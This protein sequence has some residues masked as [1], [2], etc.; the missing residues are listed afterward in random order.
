MMD[1]NKHIVDQRINKIVKD[2]PE[3]FESDNDYNKKLSK[4]FLILGMASYLDFELKDVLPLITEGGNDCGIDA[5]YI[6][7]VSETEFTVILFQS[8][9]KF[10]LEN[11]SNFPA[12]SIIRVIDAV[13]GI[14][15]PSRDLLTNNVIKPKITEIQSLLLDGNIPNIIC[16][17]MNN[18]DSWNEEGN[19]HIK[20]ANFGDQVVFEHYNHKKIVEHI[21]K[22][23]PVSDTISI[24]GKG[25]VEEFNFKRVLI[26]KISVKEIVR[27]ANNHGDSLF[28]KNI[29][30]Y[31]GINKN[32]VNEAIR[33]T[34]VD[35]EKKNNFFFYNNGITMVCTKFS[36][37]A[38]ASENWII[39]VEDMQIINGGQTCKTIQETI[40]NNP[41]IDYSQVYVL[42]RLYEVYPY[43]DDDVI[44]DITIATNSQ[45]PV[46]LRDLKANEELQRKLEMSVKGLGFTYKRKREGVSSTDAIPSSVAAEAVC[47]I[48]RRKP[49]V[50]KYKRNELFGKFYNDIFNNLNAAQLVL[51]VLIFRYCDNQRKKMP[52][53]GL[54]SH[55]PYSNYFMAMKLGDLLLN[56]MGVEL[57]DLTHS[58]FDKARRTFENK[59][60]ELYREANQFIIEALKKYYNEED[61][62][63]IDPR[64]LAA[65]FRRGDF[66]LKLNS[67]KE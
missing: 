18:G 6:G 1:I 42:L 16:V 48:W 21:T 67:V 4:A 60:G 58:N 54:N 66:M 31:L 38:L 59:K 61:Y 53:D 55:I 51:A 36:Y 23:K 2:N 43:N 8:K 7:D 50:A 32:R 40:N 26:G 33:S 49:H 5:I 37:N 34:L 65:I 52:I 15:D 44:T 45:N 63:N 11:D 35:D 62:S 46:D 64:R 56:E 17:L 39:K 9:Y 30:K 20:N 29:R 57:K 12:N 10:D 3:W 14:F 41:D 22:A 24:S 47:A 28:E 25:I 27:L 19:I 13:K